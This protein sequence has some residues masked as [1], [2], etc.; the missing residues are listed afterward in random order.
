MEN[1]RIGR[2]LTRY[3]SRQV[4]ENLRASKGG[5][6]IVLSSERRRLTILFADLLGFSSFSDRNEAEVVDRIINEYLTEMAALIEA[7][8]G[9]VAR[10]MGDGIMAFFG[11]PAQMEP[12][13]QALRAV[14]AAVAMQGKMAE[15]GRKW[16]ASGLDHSLQL[17]VGISQD[18]ATV[19]NFGSKDLMEYTAIGSA[20]NLAA[21]LEAACTPGC[22]LVSFPVY[23]A[24]K[25]AFPYTEPELREFKGFTHPVNVA[26][27]YPGGAENPSGMVS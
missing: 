14:T 24:S 22:V 8:G 4:I 6:G 18:Y 3:H 1:L 20:V 17:R 12:A 27:L 13:D 16:L 9:T 21:R 15:L 26:E 5:E 19:G 23:V 25:G 7:Q 10:F 11:A 2:S